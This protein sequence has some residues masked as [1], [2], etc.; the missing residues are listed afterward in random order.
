MPAARLLSL[1]AIS[2][3]E[4]F[5]I[6]AATTQPPDAGLAL[7]PRQIAALLSSM[8]LVVLA[9]L[10]L[11]YPWLNRRISAR[12]LCRATA[13]VLAVGVYPFVP[14]LPMLGSGAAR[15]VALGGLLAVRYAASS[16]CFTSLNI[17]VAM[18]F[19]ILECRHSPAVIQMNCSVEPA[20]R[21]A[22]NGIAQSV[23][24]LLRTIGPGASGLVWSWGLKSGLG[25][26][27]NHSLVVSAIRTHPHP[28]S[29]LSRDKLIWL[30]HQF[31]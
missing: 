20:A 7:R 24:S 13:L 5:P 16:V 18:P 8:G 29:I 26:P 9:T 12:G 15:R 17:L 22:W 6:F 14:M 25:A 31:L 11:G 28:S 3:D 10:L 4:V 19:E 30:W 23:V 2:F 21:G 27:L 1:H